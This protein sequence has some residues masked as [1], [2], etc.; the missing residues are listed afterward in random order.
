MPDEVLVAVKAA[1]INPGEIAIREGRLQERWPATFP[2]GEGTDFAG[3]CRR[4]G[5][6]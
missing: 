4:S 5:T 3:L 6:V 2:S 1:G